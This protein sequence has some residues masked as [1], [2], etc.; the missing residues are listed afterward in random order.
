MDMAFKAT[1]GKA[2]IEGVSIINDMLG[3]D[4]TREVDG[5]NSPKL[6]ISE[7]CQ[8]LIFSLKTWTGADGKKS[9]SKDFI[10][11][12]RYIALADGVGYQDP[13]ALRVRGGGCY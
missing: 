7:R 5:T 2:I 10:D 11:I 6:Y 4:D 9:A 3:Y 12:L 1:S 8:N 13:D